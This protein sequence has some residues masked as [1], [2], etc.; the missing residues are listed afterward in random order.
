[1]TKTA[2]RKTGGRWLITCPCG[3][4]WITTHHRLAVLFAVE[5]AHRIEVAA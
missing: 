2:I 4:Q 1:M 5:H 3:Y